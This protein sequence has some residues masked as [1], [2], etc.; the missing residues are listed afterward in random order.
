MTDITIEPYEGSRLRLLPFFRLADESEAHVRSYF[1]T[2][3]VLIACVEGEIA[4][5][6][7]NRSTRC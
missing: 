3:R 1:E 7:F 4:G 5:M 2:G 6:L